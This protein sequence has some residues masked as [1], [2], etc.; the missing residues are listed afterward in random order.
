MNFK[1]THTLSDDESHVIITREVEGKQTEV[2][3]Q[4]EGKMLEKMIRLQH[5]KY[6]NET[7]TTIS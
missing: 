2:E 6:E 5:F 7:Q 1:T 3:K 4:Y